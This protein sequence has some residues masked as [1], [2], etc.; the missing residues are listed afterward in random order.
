MSKILRILKEF[1]LNMMLVFLVLIMIVLMYLNWTKGL[2]VDSMPEDFF[3]YNQIMEFIGERETGEYEIQSQKLVAP[4]KISIKSEREYYSA[5]YDQATSLAVYNNL[6]LEVDDIENKQIFIE[7]SNLDEFLNA[8]D[9]DTLAYIEFLSP[10]SAIL[11][12]ESDIFVTDMVATQQGKNIELFIKSREQFFKLTMLDSSL[13]FGNYQSLSTEYDLVVT[14]EGV[15]NLIND[16]SISVLQAEI[17][18]PNIDSDMELQ[19]IST[20]LYNPAIVTNYETNYDEEIYVN[21]YSAI[22][23]ANDYLEFESTDPRGNIFYQ[24]YNLSATQM[25]DFSMDIFNDIYGYIGSNIVAHPSD[26][27]YEDSQTIVVLSAKLGGI[28][29][30]AGETFGIFTFSSSGLSYCK[31]NMLFAQ[32]EQTKLSLI[33]TSLLDTQNKII[34]SYDL[35]GKAGFK[36]YFDEE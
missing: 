6:F 14:E 30:N 12:I 13:L 18:E 10:L 15:I 2:N 23:I 36:Y 34:I 25:I 35:E 26:I 16:S 33:K 3:A 31:I 8:L 5:V 11:N 9:L 17:S 22:T 27:Y 7:D 19:I 24:Q 1:I 29:V 21:E 32:Q 4:D 28:N 20:F